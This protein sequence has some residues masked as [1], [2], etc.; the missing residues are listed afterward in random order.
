MDISTL[1]FASGRPQLSA[2]E[3]KIPWDEP[4]FSQR[5]LENHLSQEHDWASR[6][7][8]VIEQQVTWIA[9]Q[10]PAGARILDLGCGPGFYTRLLA[11]RGFHCTGVDFSPA[12]IEWARQQAQTTG[13]NMDYIHQDIRTYWPEAPFD[14][15]MMTFGELNVFSAT[16]AHA[17]ISRCAQWLTP[18]GRLLVEVHTFE[19]VKRQGMAPA[20]WQRCTHGLFL[21][22]PHLLLTE[23]A[24][25]EEAQTSATQFW[26]IEESGR[27]TRFGSQMTAWRDEEYVSLLGNAGLNVLKR[28]DSTEWPVSETFEGKLFAL[29][30]EKSQSP[31]GSP[32]NM[33]FKKGVN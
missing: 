24:W 12:S 32:L 21:G 4:A 31:E 7:Q 6:R 25:D 13:L 29:L 14:F 11:E 28:P 1:I 9:R 8:T 27:T 5:M 15:I 17:L 2:D 22:V 10:L 33:P 18:G 23:N 26:A 30:A 20:S 19:E 16:D 3:S